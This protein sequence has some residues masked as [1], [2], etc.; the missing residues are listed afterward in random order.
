M[1]NKCFNMLFSFIL[2]H[3]ALLLSFTQKHKIQLHK[4]H[5]LLYKHSLNLECQLKLWL[6]LQPS[7]QNKKW[8]FYNSASYRYVQI[9]IFHTYY[10][11]MSVV[12]F[13]VHVTWFL[14]RLPNE[15]RLFKTGVS[16]F[17]GKFVKWD[18]RTFSSRICGDRAGWA[19]TWCA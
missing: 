11:N 2:F 14:V 19:K 8:V 13:Y 3:C 12:S 1:I 5:M 4:I 18:V 15:R 9:G 7:R 17:V 16:T 10:I 6:S